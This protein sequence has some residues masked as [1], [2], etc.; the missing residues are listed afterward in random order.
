MGLSGLSRQA[1][2]N[3]SAVRS[4]QTGELIAT[5]DTTGDTHV[6]LTPDPSAVLISSAAYQGSVEILELWALPPPATLGRQLAATA[7]LTL[8]IGGGV[9][10]A[11]RRRTR[12]A[13]PTAT[14]GSVR[15]AA[16]G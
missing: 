13:K 2:R 14:P 7:G 6:V 15:E 11:A 3:T 1:I 12:A 8:I 4:A 16:A 5:Y 10:L 9:W